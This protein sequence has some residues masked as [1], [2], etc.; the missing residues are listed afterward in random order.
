MWN[1][2]AKNV[3]KFT[4]EIYVNFGE[5]VNFLDLYIFQVNFVN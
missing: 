5:W 3:R 4:G 1:L 2:A